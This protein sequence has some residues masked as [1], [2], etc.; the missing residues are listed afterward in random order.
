MLL[1]EE[2]DVFCLEK[3][4]IWVAPDV[5]DSIV[6]AQRLVLPKE[7]NHLYSRK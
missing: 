3:L 6:D 1:L 5:F 4:M 7:G 2:I